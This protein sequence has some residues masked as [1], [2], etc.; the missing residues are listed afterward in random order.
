M[1]ILIIGG[2]GI[3]SS[4]FTKHVI[5]Q[6][7]ELY[8]LNRGKRSSN[9]NLQYAHCIISDIREDDIETIQNKLEDIYFDVV[10]DFLTFDVD[11]MKKTLAIIKNRFNQ[12]VFI[13]SATAYKKKSENEILTE[14][15]EV[16]NE[17]WQYAYN[18]SK[19]EEFLRKKDINYTIIRPYVT[20]G[21]T[22]IPFPIIPDGYNYTLLA[23]ILE[24]KPVLLY[25]GGSAICTLT[26]TKDFAEILYK[27]LLNPKAFK[28][29]F[30]ITSNSPQT[31]KDVYLEYCKILKRKP[32]II[33]VDINQ[34][35]K[36]MPEFSDI[37][38]G[39]K[40][41][42]MVFDNSKVLNAI[43]GYQFKN[44]I[45]HYLEDSV[46]YYLNEE[47]LHCIDNKW[48]GRCDY[49][50]KRVSGRKLNK[51]KL[52]KNAKKKNLQFWHAIMYN[53]VLRYLF[54]IMKK[55]KNRIKG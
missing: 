8:L 17:N 28:E 9:I 42:N 3:L 36:Y 31:W 40:G 53:E 51:L 27:L 13:S 15:S 45:S 14:N 20:F 38:T 37:L 49:L 5:L 6:K 41:T 16:G 29:A 21:N 52:N 55:M 46:K 33:S 43:G 50:I 1:K 35:N 23:R 7:D 34:I 18:K 26:S 44:S 47:S 48:D 32:N 25:N 22:R 30:H 54:D 12:Y 39:D 19:C 10:V 2:S 4:D 11:Q 24:N